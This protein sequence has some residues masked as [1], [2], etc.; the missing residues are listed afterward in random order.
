MST[1]SEYK[2]NLPL[3]DKSYGFDRR[4]QMQARVLEG[5]TPLPKPVTYTDI[6]SAMKEWV[7][8]KFDF[9]TEGSKMP[10]YMLLSNQRISEYVQ[11]W[12]MLDKNGNYLMNFKTINRELT[13]ENGSILGETKNIPGN[14]YYAIGYVPVTQENGTVGYD[15]YDMRQPTAVDLQYR[16]GFVSN[17]LDSIN[18]FNEMI[19]REFNSGYSYICPNGHYMSIELSSVSDETE[20]SIDDRRYYSQ[21]YTI[22]VKAYIVLEDDF[23]IVHMPIRA[24]INIGS[25]KFGGNRNIDAVVCTNPCNCIEEDHLFYPEVRIDLTIPYR[26]SIKELCEEIIEIEYEYNETYDARVDTIE[27]SNVQDL[28]LYINGEEIDFEEEYTITNGDIIKI[29]FSRKRKTENSSV[30]VVCHDPN[31]VIDTQSEEFKDNGWEEKNVILK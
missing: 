30:C 22:K 28:I 19:L 4:Y 7:E 2:Y 27:T 20:N 31:K 11:K 6:D 24:T 17:K 18:K 12:S 1:G 16:I 29:S 15:R 10:T 5:S 25:N 21:L 9:S 14:R 8:K 23:R 26:P 13:P 3:T